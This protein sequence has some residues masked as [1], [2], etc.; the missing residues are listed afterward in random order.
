MLRRREANPGA[1]MP[2]P[3]TDNT[4]V[5]T[6]YRKDLRAGLVRRV[7]FSEVNMKNKA[8]YPMMEC[9]IMVALA[10][11]LSFLTLFKLPLGGSVTV[12]SMLPICMLSI[13]RGLKWGL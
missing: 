13:R 5:G 9:T 1:K 11:G 3:D 12:L 6:K 7:F 8:L 4:G 2:E 10:T